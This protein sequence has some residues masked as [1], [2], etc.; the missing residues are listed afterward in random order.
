MFSFS[1]EESEASSFVLD[2]SL[3]VWV[4]QALDIG[5]QGDETHQAWISILYLL[6]TG[7]VA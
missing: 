5:K 3:T 6:P 4:I 2:Q 7:S 1:H